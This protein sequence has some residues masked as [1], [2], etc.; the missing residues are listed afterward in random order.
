MGVD[1]G[2]DRIRP[3]KGGKYHLMPNVR[4]LKS[5]IGNGAGYQPILGVLYRF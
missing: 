1:F 3:V 2:R 5:S 4:V